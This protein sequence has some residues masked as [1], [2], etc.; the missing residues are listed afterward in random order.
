[1]PTNGSGTSR[2]FVIGGSAGAIEALRKL[3]SHLPEDFPAPILVV[4]HTPPDSPGALPQVVARRS[5]LLVHN[6][7][8]GAPL[9]PA[10]VYM[11]PPGFHLQVED[12][13]MRLRGGPTEN[14]HRPAIDPL[15]RSAA[16][17]YG[18]AAVGII[19]SGY[20]DDGSGG[21]FRI[22]QAGGVAIVQDPEDALV[23]DMPRNAAERTEPDYSVPIREL[24][25]LM[26]E[27]A[28]ETVSPRVVPMSEPTMNNEP[29]PGRRSVFTCPDCNGTLWEVEEGGTLRFRCRVGHAY[30]ADSMLEEQ[31]MDVERAL[32]AA[33]RTLEENAELSHRLAD[34]ARHHGFANS[35]RR[36]MDRAH[37][38]F[39]NAK[40]LRELLTGSKQVPVPAR[41]MQD[42]DEEVSAD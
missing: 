20:L 23:G 15:F 22:K 24:A 13:R 18:P 33:L 21:L 34:R 8:D 40:V 32:W 2:V 26:I 4:V 19:L 3:F 6:A 28:K 14:R 10:H 41:P 27:L 5:R 16:H 35:E 38:S 7:I 29:Q 36:Y 37:E 17:W 42:L 1:M 11:A 9:Q 12:G 31:N 39:V 25:P 30:T